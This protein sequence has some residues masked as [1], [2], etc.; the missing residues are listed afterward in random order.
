MNKNLLLFLFVLFPALTP[1]TA[2]AD[3]MTFMPKEIRDAEKPSIEG[4]R[5]FDAE[6]PEASH[7]YSVNGRT[8]HYVESRQE[9]APRPLV[10]FVHGSPGLWRTWIPYLNDPELQSQANM[11]AMDRP[12]FGASGSGEVEPDFL[13]QC[14]DLEPLLSHAQANQ[15][16]I[17][18][19]HALGGALIARM[20]MVFPDK[21]TDL[22]MT[23][24]PLDPALQ[25]EDWF[26][27]PANW[28][29]VTWLLPREIVVFNR[30]YLG[31]EK[32]LREMLPL[33]PKITQRVSLLLGEEDKEVP[34]A[35]A[36]FAELMLTQARSLNVVR[37][38]HMNHFIPWTRY[39]MVKAEVLVHG[40]R[41][42]EQ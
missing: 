42:P 34:V 12:G 30:E 14:Q 23:A 17:L 5:R 27:Y 22:V 35:N 41:P 19:G 20:A 32:Q 25:K 10:I 13:K 26:Q 6:H 9:G 37:I 11:I 24:A 33:W 8:I 1:L 7:S 38:P 40:S 36:E 28:P 21:V 3:V 15:R 4:A 18:V 39:E 31:L 16:V 29:P 2:C